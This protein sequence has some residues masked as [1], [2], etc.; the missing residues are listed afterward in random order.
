M[1]YH[2]IRTFEIRDLIEPRVIRLMLNV[3]NV[4]HGWCSVVL[5]DG[6]IIP[7][8]TTQ[9]L[10]SEKMSTTRTIADSMGLTALQ[11]AKVLGRQI[12][13]TRSSSLGDLR[14]SKFCTRNI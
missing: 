10:I 1:K 4:E 2:N 8:P 7:Q 5:P 9:A 13:P 12:A 6:Y 14:E 3:S 11:Y